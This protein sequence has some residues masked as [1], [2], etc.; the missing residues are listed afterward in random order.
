L[1]EHNKL[2]EWG[3]K[4]QAGLPG[5]RSAALKGSS[6]GLYPPRQN[7]RKKGILPPLDFQK[8]EKRN[9]PPFGFPKNG[10]KEYSPLW[11]FK[12]WKKGILPPLDFQKKLYSSFDFFITPTFLLFSL[13]SLIEGTHLADLFNSYI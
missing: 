3:R 10:K 8:M 7:L 12:K 1:E 6:Q 13:Q 9:T 4:V 11:I 5:K 2:V